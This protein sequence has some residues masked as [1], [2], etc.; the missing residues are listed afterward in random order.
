MMNELVT[1]RMDTV[2]KVTYLQVIFIEFGFLL[3]M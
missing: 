1:C 2:G 3:Y